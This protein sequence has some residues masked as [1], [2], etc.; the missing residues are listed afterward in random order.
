[1]NKNQVEGN[2][3]DLK[4]DENGIEASSRPVEEKQLKRSR[5]FSNSS[6][7]EYL[8]ELSI[9]IIGVLVTLL[10]TNMISDYK[11]QKEIEGMLKFV[12]AEL[13]D[14]LAELEHVGWRWTGEQHLFRLMQENTDNL[15]RIPADTLRKYEYAIGALYGLTVKTDSY[16]LLRSS[17]LVQYVKDKDLLRKLSGTYG[18]LRNLNGQLSSYTTQKRLLFAEPL[19]AELSEKELRERAEGNTY[20]FFN[21]IAHKEE[22]RKFAFVS[23]TIL[24]PPDIFD[25]CRSAVGETM[26]MLEERGY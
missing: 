14:N 19:I 17:M 18:E 16:E 21:Y 4:T 25:E 5:L 20:E 13:A 11:R 26:R 15:E 24:S 8:R 6:V 9:V 2:N 3:P 12:R 7:S 22:F 10:I 1:M 23:R